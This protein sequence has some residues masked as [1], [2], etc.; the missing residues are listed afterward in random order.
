MTARQDSTSQEKGRPPTGSG[1]TRSA[2]TKNRHI[3]EEYLDVAVS[4]DVAYDQWLQY[5]KWSEIFK[6]E[7]AQAAKSDGDDS[8]NDDGDVKAGSKIGPSK[9]EWTAEILKREPGRR[10]EWRSKGGAH[11]EGVA[12]FNRLGPHL[13]HLTVNMEYRPAGVFETVGNFFRMPRRRVRKDLKLFKNY[14]EFRGT[15]TGSGGGEIKG[16]GIARD[17]DE[18]LEQA[19]PDSHEP[20]HQEEE[21][22]T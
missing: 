16:P 18:Q 20:P 19:D 21:R 1:G 22:G 3:I 17:V 8:D 5:D 7:H 14:I 6:H 15:A 2:L 12:I 9:R 11:V 10:V 4:N 13:T